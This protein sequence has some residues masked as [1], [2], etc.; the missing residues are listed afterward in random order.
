[1]PSIIFL[2]YVLNTSISTLFIR[3]IFSVLSMTYFLSLLLACLYKKTFDETSQLL[4]SLYY[5]LSFLSMSSIRRPPI[6]SRDR[7]GMPL[8]RRDHAPF[9]LRHLIRDGDRRLS[10][11]VVINTR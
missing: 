8:T 10:V 7:D 2:P 1:M 3:T 4:R 11:T 9:V 5:L 6:P